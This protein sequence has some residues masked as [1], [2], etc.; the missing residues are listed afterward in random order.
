MFDEGLAHEAAADE[1]SES[2]G[3]EQPTCASE[4]ED[5]EGKL[6]VNLLALI[7]AHHPTGK[8]DEIF[9][10]AVLQLRRLGWSA[11]AI[12]QLLRRYPAGIAFKFA[13]DLRK[14]VE[15][16]YATA[17][18][19]DSFLDPWA[20][21]IVPVFPLETLPPGIGDFVVSEADSIGADV[22][23]MAV[24]TLVALGG[25]IHHEIELK[26][27]R[28]GGW[29][30]RP[31]LWGMLVGPPSSKRDLIIDTATQQLEEH[32]LHRQKD[33]RRS[34]A[35]EISIAA[36][37]KRKPSFLSMQP[38]TLV[39]HD[40][41]A[42]ALARLLHQQDRGVLIKAHD[43]SSIFGSVDRSNS[44]GASQRAFYLRGY[45]G[46]PHTERRIGRDSD[47]IENLC[48]GVIGG[49]DP[50]LLATIC[51]PTSDGLLH[52]GWPVMVQASRMPQ[53]LPNDS[54]IVSNYRAIVRQLL[55]CDPG[56]L[57]MDDA[58]YGEM[59]ALQFE[60]HEF[61][62]ASAGYAH[63]FQTFLG[64][65]PRMAGSLALILHMIEIPSGMFD[66]P[67]ET[68]RR[69]R[70]IVI[71]FM[72]PHAHVFYDT[73]EGKMQTERIRK[74]ASFILTS[75]K[76]RIVASDLTSGVAA[77]RGLNVLDLHKATSRLVTGGWLIPEG[78]EPVARAWRV[79]PQVFATFAERRESEEASKAQLAEL[80]N[81]PRK[82]SIRKSLTSASV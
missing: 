51:D 54:S 65:V 62:K 69:A 32:E 30:A 26:L 21:Y 1:G 48:F 43:L 20:D 6:P 3:Q 52:R 50:R 81:S 75:G 7:K 25:A 46:G 34:V 53:D 22:S 2:G 39:V 66:V 73:I 9:Q 61:E 24:A 49:I 18:N 11:D 55:E 8:R 58:A 10:Y 71:E 64:K 17:E 15:I 60:L 44:T 42:K 4:S 67:L 70:K 31:N 74:I 78:T 41:S 14:V 47:L 79:A 77:L 5:A 13:A 19:S 36:E 23:A 35:E 82:S 38:A 76:A 59:Q 29:T 57:E 72:L 16:S 28:H 33:H 80:M 27:Q 63:G 40:T 68:V 56:V 37:E 45:E 12:E